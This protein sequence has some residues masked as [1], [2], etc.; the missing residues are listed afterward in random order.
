[1]YP[2]IYLL[3][4]L[5]VEKMTYDVKKSQS[6]NDTTPRGVL[7]WLIKN[8]HML[9]VVE[10]LIMYGIN[11]EM[12]KVE[13]LEK[14]APQ[15]LAL[16][17]Y[18]NTND[19]APPNQDVCKV[20]KRASECT[21]FTAAESSNK[22][23]SR[24]GIIK[25]QKRNMTKKDGFAG[26][27]TGYTLPI[28]YAMY[29]AHICQ[30]YLNHKD[31][32]ETRLTVGEY[33][34]NSSG[35]V[36]NRYNCIK[37]ANCKEW[38]LDQ[39]HVFGTYH[40]ILKFSDFEKAFFG[41]NI[42]TTLRDDLRQQVN[43]KVTSIHIAMSRQADM[44]WCLTI[45]DPIVHDHGV[46]DKLDKK[47][48]AKELQERYD[49]SC[50]VLSGLLFLCNNTDADEDPATFVRNV[51]EYCKEQANEALTEL[52]RRSTMG[53]EQAKLAKSKGKGGNIKIEIDYHTGEELSPD[54]KMGV[55]RFLQE[56]TMEDDDSSVDDE[57][58]TND[59]IKPLTVD[60]V[61]AIISQQMK[62]KS[63][64]EDDVDRFKIIILTKDEAQ[65]DRMFNGAVDPANKEL[66]ALQRDWEILE[67]EI[68]NPKT[69]KYLIGRKVEV[70]VTTPPQKKQ[71]KSNDQKKRSKG[72]CMQKYMATSFYLFI[73]IIPSHEIE[74]NV[75]KR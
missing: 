26:Q 51:Q 42:R 2:K 53:K 22:V 14:V 1:M 24:Y 20:W 59:E 69:K 72:K 48:R 55:K 66:V 27:K 10:G 6:K 33:Q 9:D 41:T 19:D 30:D 52:Y 58:I 65:L 70:P 15:W 61:K 67:P 13:I 46:G 40:K 3:V 25:T 45:N 4:E 49:Y 63:V 28:F 68:V 11:P 60:E 18:I 5:Q 38:K 32:L 23:K 57:P 44:G 8:G 75:N 54:A 56:Q 39:F 16:D 37:L 74:F 7:T 21:V 73:I 12:N 29:S 47:D 34:G 17:E 35:A 50:N 31:P 64:D 62:I 43:K 71:K 36:Q